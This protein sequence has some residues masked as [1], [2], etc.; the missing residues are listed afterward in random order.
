MRLGDIAWLVVCAIVTALLVWDIKRSDTW[1][2]KSRSIAGIIL[3]DLGTLLV[4]F[5]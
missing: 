2:S 3:L 5:T 1:L 4:M